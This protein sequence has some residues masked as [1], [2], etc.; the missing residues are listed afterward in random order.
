MI[1]LEQKH[2]ITA[3][4]NGTGLD[5]SEMIELKEWRRREQEMLQGRLTGFDRP[6]VLTDRV[7]GYIKEENDAYLARISGIYETD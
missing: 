1:S 5:L 3:I 4:L 7:R 6:P 2:Q